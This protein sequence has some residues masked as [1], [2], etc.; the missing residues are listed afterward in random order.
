MS[1]GD[2]NRK[3]KSFGNPT[4]VRSGERFTYSSGKRITYNNDLLEETEGKLKQQPAYCNVV[5]GKSGKGESVDEIA[6]LAGQMD[7][8]YQQMHLLIK[9]TAKALE[10][11]RITVQEMDNELAASYIVD[12]GVSCTLKKKKEKEDPL[13]LK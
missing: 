6:A 1:G 2:Q 8:I 4:P 7:A 3:Q 12:D 9:A 13:M 11:I 10:S 5:P